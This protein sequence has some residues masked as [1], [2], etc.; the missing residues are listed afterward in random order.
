MASGTM[1]KDRPNYISYLLRLWRVSGDDGPHR[2]GKAVWRA[3]LE[4]P[5]TRERKVFATLDDLRA[6][7]AGLIAACLL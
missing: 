1:G 6:E 4:D 2:P 5:H 3:S 7:S